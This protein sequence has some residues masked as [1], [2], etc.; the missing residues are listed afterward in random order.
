MRSLNVIWNPVLACRIRWPH[1]KIQQWHSVYAVIGLLWRFKHNF[2]SKNFDYP[3][4]LSLPDHKTAQ[5]PWLIWL[6]DG[7]VT[8]LAWLIKASLMWGLKDA[9][10][11][12]HRVFKLG[13]NIFN[14]T[15]SWLHTLH[16]TKL[17]SVC[18]EFSMAYTVSKKGI[19]CARPIREVCFCSK[20]SFLIWNRWDF[21]N[22]STLLQSVWGWSGS[23]QST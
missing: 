12:H 7:D 20:P 8:I 19:C 18:N 21:L 11:K 14:K 13:Q 22:L 6:F 4:G 2:A 16:C 23:P 10:S 17:S 1:L 9:L 15:T 5:I 3:G